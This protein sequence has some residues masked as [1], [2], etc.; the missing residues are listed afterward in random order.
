MCRGYF[1]YFWTHPLPADEPKLSCKWLP[2]RC[3]THHLND[4]QGNTL[5]TTHCTNS[6]VAPAIAT[7]FALSALATLTARADAPPPVPAP[8]DNAC[9]A[10]NEI[11]FE[12]AADRP[13]S[14]TSARHVTD[15]REALAWQWMFF[16]R[17]VVQGL[18]LMR[19]G[20]ADYQVTSL[21]GHC[22]VEGYVAPA[23][24]FLITLPAQERWNGDI[25]LNGCDAFCGL[26][27]EDATVSGLIHGYATIT[28]DGGHINRPWFDGTWGYNNRQ[29]EIDFGYEANHL[30]AQVV[31]AVAAA[32]YGR[33]HSSAFITGFSKGGHAGIKS[34]LT[35]PR[36]FDGVLS[37]APVVQYQDINAIRLP[38]LYKS[39]TRADGTHILDEDDAPLIHRAAIAS[40]DAADG[41]K[42]GIIGD[43]RRCRFDP[44]VLE[45]R[46][47]IGNGQCLSAE[48]VAALR[49]IYAQPTNDR[50]QL[51]YPYPV[52]V[53]S[54]L[55][56]HGFV[57]A[58]RPGGDT[59]QGEML[60][61]T[62]L[63]YLAFDRDPGPRFEWLEFDPVRDHTRL[64]ALRSIY[65]AD[66]TD[67]RAFRDAGGK[68]IVIHGW[69]DGAVSA[70]MTIDWYERL[71]AAMGDST[72]SFVKLY[73]S[74]GSKHG[75]GGDGPYV[76]ESFA[77]LRAWVKK[78]TTPDALIFKQPD[79]KTG[80]ILRSRPVFPYPAI[81]RY[82]GKG[83]VNDAANFERAMP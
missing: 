30:G 40:C 63:R 67:L 34:A 79:E 50:G 14:I 45:C 32:Y 16:K 75:H 47:D 66:G 65:D 57:V 59:Y 37:R 36:D 22:R 28:T 29:A 33:K 43:P 62:W 51:S 70:R 61:R 39:N 11:S 17:S 64:D 13:V 31:K 27:D 3:G 25:I 80:E 12:T 71:R 73:L 77:A 24:R 44:G 49:K 48:Q 15:A 54:E 69:S 18:P 1:M 10:L 78:G 56:W 20:K 52:D 72:D 4:L 46:G 74:S 9:A 35:H 5:D 2:Q 76:N 38:Y 60:G 23:V 82:T 41:L 21:P 53:G 68:M 19:D 26:I 8:A 81:T 83:D 7:L 55:D 42:D 58:N 6:A